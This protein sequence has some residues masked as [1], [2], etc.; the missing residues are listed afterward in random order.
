MSTNDVKLARVTKSTLDYIV[1]E[2]KDIRKNM[3]VTK[4]A[5]QQLEMW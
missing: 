3:V 5:K 1:P 4:G 2:W